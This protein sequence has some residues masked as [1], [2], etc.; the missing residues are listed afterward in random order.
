MLKE[1]LKNKK[2]AE[3]IKEF[4]KRP[5]ILD[6]IIFGSITRGKE[7]PKDID[8]LIIYAKKTKNIIDINY[9]LSKKLKKVSKKIE[10]I[11]KEYNDIFKPE[12]FARESILSEGFSMQQKKF[13]SECFGY[14]NFVLF[15]YS[16]KKMNKSKRMRF[17]YSLNGRGK[18]KGILKKNKCYKFADKIILSP[19]ENSETMK[20]FLEKWEIKFM[21]FPVIIPQK[22]VKYKF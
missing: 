15:K 16:L 12:F 9:E 6:V 13:V 5:E 8:L 1:L 4:L 7:K 14:D 11:G 17:Y 2:F 22:T 3:I 20:N 18:E 10:I 19:I 21:Q